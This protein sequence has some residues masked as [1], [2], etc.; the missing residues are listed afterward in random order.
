MIIID[1]NN[2]I[3][4]L[5]T[6]Q[7]SYV[8]RI[9]KN[10]SLGHLYYGKP[11]PQNENFDYL[12]NDKNKAAGT[13]KYYEDDNKFSLA[14]EMSEFNVYGTGDFRQPAIEIKISNQLCYPEFQYAEY[15]ITYGKER[16]PEFPQVYGDEYE[17]LTITLNDSYLQL[18]L[19]LNYSITENSSAIIRSGILINNSR[20]T[21]TISK[22]MSGILDIPS[23]HFDFISLSGA[24][25]RERHLIRQ[26]LRMGIQSV[27]STRGSSSHHHNP[28]IMLAEKN[29]DEFSGIVYGASLIYSG[30]FIAQTEVDE[31]DVSR[32][33]IGIN[34]LNFTW[35]LDP[36]SEFKTPECIFAVTENGFN[37][38]S[39][40]FHDIAVNNIISPLWKHSE[41]PIV[42]NS[43]EASHF[44]FTE[45]SLLNLAEL[46]K[47]IGAD[48][49]VVD[50]GWFGERDST[51]KSLGD[52]I[53]DRK[54][55]PDGIE[56]FSDK[57][58]EKGLK[59]GLWFE[60]EMLNPDSN[61]YRSH[62][63]WSLGSINMRRSFGRGQF[64]LDMTNPEVIEYLKSAID[65]MIERS[66]LDYIK[67]DM[68]RNITEA[69]S[70]Y[71][72]IDRQGELFHR[73]MIGVY[74]LMSH[75][76]EKYPNIIIENCASGGG[77]FD[78]GMLYYSPQIWTSDDSDAAERLKIQYGTSICYPLSSMSNH[79]TAVPNQ[80]TD[81]TV[82]LNFR[83]DVASFGILG[84]ELDLSKISH[85]KLNEI[86]I[87][88]NRYKKQQKLILSG[89]FWRLKS[90][91]D[92]NE[93]AWEVIS[94]NGEEILVGWY[95]LLAKPN[96]RNQEYLKLTG[97]KE[98]S[99]YK[100]NNDNSIL[101]GAALM[102]IGLRLPYD[103]NGANGQ[104][105][106]ISG[107]FQSRT[108]ILKKIH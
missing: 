5:K 73:Y 14:S 84:Y 2:K 90:P 34:P 98:D 25:L 35:Q 77:R 49:L 75:I 66:N 26:P 61:L 58:H 85:D 45:D 59:L 57:I 70:N 97:L 69:Y 53:E 78:F 93:T 8:F 46:A 103:F 100:V 27:E 1:K 37:G 94:E 15:N 105:A 102:N 50:D 99:Y 43:W 42:V 4:H 7:M 72:S 51:R 29:S 41:R 9:L 55:F 106:E 71:L 83:N 52:W 63:E 47:E 80:Q 82:P 67:W 31:W 36:S 60:P 62:P 32:T 21:Y 81:R 38:I 19:K 48:T 22:F 74:K 56:S 101:S 11:L 40:I 12:I 39:H 54:K 28:F 20:R 24:W 10:G 76:C 6:N 65:N 91:F 95:K 30:S 79:I 96:Q 86:R 44:D 23:S 13:I 18:S 16:N 3:F 88:L 107:D 92:G 68:N 89:R 17:T 104:T 108:F 64:V 33:L 87:Q